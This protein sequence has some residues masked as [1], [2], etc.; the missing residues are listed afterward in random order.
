[1][2]IFQKKIQLC[3]MFDHN[4]DSVRHS[5]QTKSE[6]KF[7]CSNRTFYGPGKK[8]LI[9]NALGIFLSRNQQIIIYKNGMS[10][11]GRKKVFLQ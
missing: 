5:K 4:N 1:M 11:F 8:W 6:S 3:N 10:H 2:S 7:A 9:K